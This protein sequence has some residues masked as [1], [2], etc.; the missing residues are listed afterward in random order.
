MAIGDEGNVKWVD[1]RILPR[2]RTTS[3]TGVSFS[4]LPRRSRLDFGYDLTLT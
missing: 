4:R 2:T 1:V 3:T